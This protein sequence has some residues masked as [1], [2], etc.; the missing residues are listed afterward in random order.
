VNLVPRGVEIIQQAL[1]VERSAR[2]GDGYDNP[3]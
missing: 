3:Q 1:G 2:P